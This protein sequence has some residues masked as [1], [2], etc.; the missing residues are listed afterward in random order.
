M[1]DTSESTSNF[2][3]K[4]LKPITKSGVI[5]HYGRR[6]K[7]NCRHG[8]NILIF[9]NGTVDTSDDDI[10]KHCILEFTSMAPGHVR[11]KGVE[12]NLFLAMDKTGHLY[13]EV[14]NF[15][16]FFYIFYLLIFHSCFSLILPKNP[17]FLLNN[18]KVR[19][20]HIYLLSIK[21]KNGMLL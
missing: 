1:T 21:K 3:K 5:K 20:V 15:I 10:D 13:G 2:S 8:Y 12:A 19:T 18:Q 6:M 4:S 16:Q 7:L 11:I 14:N 9:D 17:Q